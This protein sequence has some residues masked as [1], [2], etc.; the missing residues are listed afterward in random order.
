ML[1][2]L[3]AKYRIKQF[4]AFGSTSGTGMNYG[5]VTYLGFIYADAS[6]VPS[7]SIMV[8]RLHDVGKNERVPSLT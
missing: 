4:V 8:H 6:I 7:I 1:C 5:L 3:D 2:R